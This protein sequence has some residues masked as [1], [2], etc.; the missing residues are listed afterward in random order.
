MVNTILHKSNWD[1]NL[2]K[3]GVFEV[4]FSWNCDSV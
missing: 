1:E 3:G 4:T 2:E